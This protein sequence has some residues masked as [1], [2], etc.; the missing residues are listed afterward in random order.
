MVKKTRILVI[1]F[2]AAIGAGVLSFGGVCLAQQMDAQLQK[3]M[4][5][6]EKDLP[7]I[8]YGIYKG[9][10]EE[11]KLMFYHLALP[12]AMPPLIQEFKKR[13]P[14]IAVQEYFSSGGP[15]F[16]KFASE[17][18]AKKNVADIW[19]HTEI[20]AMNK[21]TDE[22]LLMKY[23]I[24]SDG[25]YP[26]AFKRPGFWYPFCFSQ[27]V[28]AWNKEIVPDEE[29][30]KRLKTWAGL[31]DPYWKGKKVGT[32]VIQ[33]G[34]TTHTAYYML[35]EKFGL[36]GWRKLAELNPQLYEGVNPLADAVASGELALGMLGSEAGFYTRYV[37][38]APVH[39]TNPDPRIVV[40]YGQAIPRDAP[41]PNAAKLFQEF[42][43]SV[44]GQRIIAGTQLPSFRVG[45]LR[46][47]AK[48]PWYSQPAAYPYNMEK[49]YSSMLGPE[50]LIN[51]WNKMFL[52]K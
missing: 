11:G 24:A 5:A 51:Q 4:K 37:R 18:R 15:L 20:G 34:G 13:F 49:I 45:D 47:H 39:W 48:E 41:H 30:V 44:P 26:E 27:V 35:H 9:A 21:L 33:S 23:Q 43:F 17:A 2:A 12:N 40:P 28:V 6:N 1:L 7:G 32:I 46:K 36:D 16:Q 38:G 31:M 8:P 3:I 29:A 50:G 22:G 10:K 19:E 25:Q 42:M 14:F 52:K